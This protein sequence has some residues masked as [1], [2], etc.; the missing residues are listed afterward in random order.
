MNVKEGSSVG[1]GVF[2]M[3]DNSVLFAA[4]LVGGGN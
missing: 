4:S 3:Q 1:I 2:S